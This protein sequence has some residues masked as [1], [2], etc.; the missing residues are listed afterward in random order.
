LDNT[1]KFGLLTSKIFKVDLIHRNQ[2]AL[3]ATD[4]NRILYLT[5]GNNVST[6]NGPA[7]PDGSMSGF[8]M[9]NDQLPLGTSVTYTSISGLPHSE[10]T[11]TVTTPQSP[12]A[13]SQLVLNSNIFI[14]P[15]LAGL[16]VSAS[17][18]P[19][20]SFP[21]ATLTRD[22][23]TNQSRMN[24]LTAKRPNASQTT[25]SKYAIAPTDVYV[26]EY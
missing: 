14:E 21:T 12:S 11:I 4:L 7:T 3:I 2:P 13:L 17:N 25:P 8:V 26:R 19:S 15:S 20:T 1:C 22:N 6:S 18:G 9:E 23:A 10:T 24:T 16:G 5:E